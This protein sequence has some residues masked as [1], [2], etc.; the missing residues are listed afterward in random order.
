M[1]DIDTDFCIER[2]NEVIEYVTDRYGEDKVA[3]NY[4]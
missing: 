4:L 2:R 1:P 3:N